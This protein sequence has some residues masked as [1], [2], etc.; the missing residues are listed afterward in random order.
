V[1]NDYLRDMSEPTLLH[2]GDA[3]E[4]ATW[5]DMRGLLPH[6]EEFWRLH[7]VPLRSKGSI[8]PRRGIDE[9]FE[10]LAMLHYSTYVRLHRAVEKSRGSGGDLRF[11]DEIYLHLYAAAELG[12][13]VVEKFCQ[14]YQQ[15]LGPK[16]VVDS[17][18]L[19]TFK[20]RFAEYRNIVHEQLPGVRLDSDRR[21]LIPVS[22][23]IGDYKRWTSVLYEARQED[24][25][26]VGL[27]INND[28]R[29]LCSA[30]EDAW[31]KMCKA[32]ALLVVNKEYLRRRDKGESVAFRLNVTAPSVSGAQVYS[33]T[34][35][36][37]VLSSGSDYPKKGH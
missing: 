20:D 25:V 21:V 12:F 3:V 17:S 10:K 37:A 7:L 24:F 5:P 16:A 34:A 9:D 26:E 14:I 1:K 13:K 2:D 4:K 29:A 31:K 33:A 23:K 28:L 30:L 22:D 19:R 8:Q 27:Q 35:V 32:S 11:P 15:C 6:Y 36:S 18:R